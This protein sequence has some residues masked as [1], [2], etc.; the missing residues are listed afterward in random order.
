MLSRKVKPK[1]VRS[2][3]V[4]AGAKPLEISLPI[5][6]RPIEPIQLRVVRELMGSL[7]TISDMITRDRALG[8]QT[9]LAV[10]SVLL[11][12]INMIDRVFPP[13]ELERQIRSGL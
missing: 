5:R 6:A 4:A 8:P 12:S 9:I 7:W 10:R 11:H 1:I 2:S 13:S 3:G